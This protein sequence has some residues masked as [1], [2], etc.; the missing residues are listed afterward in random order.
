[1]LNVVLL[2]GTQSFIQKEKKKREKDEKKRKR[3]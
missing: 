2:G 1:M 3:E